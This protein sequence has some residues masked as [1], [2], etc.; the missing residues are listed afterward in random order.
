VKDFRNCANGSQSQF[1]LKGRKIAVERVLEII[2]YIADYAFRKLLLATLGVT[3][4]VAVSFLF[5]KQFTYNSFSERLVWAGIGLNLVAGVIVMGQVGIGREFGINN[6]I[7]RTT[8][9][10]KRF[11]DNNLKIRA[12]L[13]QRYDAAILVWLVGMSCVGFGALLDLFLT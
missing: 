11:H 1:A 2:K 6:T 4:I 8:T 9:E 12:K 10:A 13:E 5:T 3:L 7:V